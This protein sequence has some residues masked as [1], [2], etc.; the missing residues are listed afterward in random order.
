MN[1]SQFP[2]ITHLAQFGENGP[3]CFPIFFDEQRRTLYVVLD[4][5]FLADPA[6]LELNARHK[7]LWSKWI[8]E[9]Q[10]RYPAGQLIIGKR[11]RGRPIALTASLA[12]ACALFSD[13][14]LTRDLVRNSCLLQFKEQLR[15]QTEKFGVAGLVRHRAFLV[16]SADSMTALAAG[17]Y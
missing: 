1:A 7:L 16:G 4:E 5:L 8:P 17:T 14:F 12:S 3:H 10:L 2:V 11:E 13:Q 6:W 15:S 9:L